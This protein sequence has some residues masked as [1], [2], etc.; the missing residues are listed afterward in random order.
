[1]SRAATPPLEPDRMGTRR[2]NAGFPALETLETEPFS[3]GFWKKKVKGERTR[4]VAA[5]DTC[6]TH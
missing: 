1:M 6:K 5:R 2:R 3:L 4:S